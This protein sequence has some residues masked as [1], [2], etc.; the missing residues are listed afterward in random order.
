MRCWNKHIPSSNKVPLFEWWE[1]RQ[2]TFREF[3]FHN[4][5]RCFLLCILFKP[6]LCPFAGLKSPVFITLGKSSA[7]SASSEGGSWPPDT[8]HVRAV[9][10]HQ[11][12]STWT[13][14]SSFIFLF[15]NKLFWGHERVTAVSSPGLFSKTQFCLIPCSVAGD[16]SGFIDILTPIFRVWE[17]VWRCWFLGLLC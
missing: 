4:R 12:S 6:G 9:G 17:Y 7:L 15:S 14:K 5:E 11:V 1:S 10:T 8:D 16:G 2:A 3:W 13:F